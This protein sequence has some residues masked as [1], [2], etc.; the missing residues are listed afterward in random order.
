MSIYSGFA[1]RAQETFY[2]KLVFKLVEMLQQRVA[3]FF[4]GRKYP[5]FKGFHLGFETD[6]AFD[7]GMFAKKLLKLH[8]TL[9]KLETNKYL[10]PHMS[11]AFEELVEVLLNNYKDNSSVNGSS[12]LGGSSAI[13]GVSGHQFSNNLRDK[14]QNQVGLNYDSQAGSRH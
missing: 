5:I 7:E 11:C 9:K 10:E 1:T 14:V 13:S 8:R 3:S 2:N 4:I 6:M 12:V